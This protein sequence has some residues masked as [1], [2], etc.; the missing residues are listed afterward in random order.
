MEKLTLDVP[1]MYGDHHV[2]EVRRL[3]SALPGI[4]DIYASSAFQIVEV[5]YDPQ[6]VDAEQI[7]ATLEKA[8]Y[9]EPLPVPIESDRAVYHSDDPNVY[10]RHS[11]AYA[12]AGQTVSFAQRVSYSG[13]PLWPCPGMGPLQR[14]DEGE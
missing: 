6:A 8:G 3:L 10:F 12:Q 9:L 14:V 11:A 4:A 13:R 7:R 2:L 1:A 5:T